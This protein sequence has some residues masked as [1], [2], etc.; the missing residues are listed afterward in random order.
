[1]G[2]LQ[3]LRD[4]VGMTDKKLLASGTPA[5]GRVVG[6]EPTNVVIGIAQKFM[7]C[8]VDVDVELDGERWRARCKHP[9]H[10]RE[11]DAFKKGH[12][13]VVV[14]VNPEDRTNIAL[15]FAADAPPKTKRRLFGG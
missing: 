7:V 3:N 6:V 4:K 14:R 15:D 2:R 11:V 9:I 10:L 13:V 8:D 5:R 12:E 1:M